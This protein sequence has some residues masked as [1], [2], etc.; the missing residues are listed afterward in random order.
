MAHLGTR[1][2]KL[3]RERKLSQ[4]ELAQRVGVNQSFISKIESGEQINPN[5]ATLKGLAKT[6]GCTTDYLVGMYE[7]ENETIELCPV[8][9]A[10]IGV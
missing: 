5:A 7:D 1:V 10:L 9:T 4:Q 8:E 3:R 2:L 6:L